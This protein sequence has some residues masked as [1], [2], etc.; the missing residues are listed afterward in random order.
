MAKMSSL[1]CPFCCLLDFYLHLRFPMNAAILPS[2]FV[3][4]AIAIHAES[5]L[6]SLIVSTVTSLRAWMPF[7]IS[8]VFLRQTRSQFLPEAFLPKVLALVS[9]CLLATRPIRTF[10]SL[11]GADRNPWHWWDQ[12]VTQEIAQWSF[13]SLTLF[14]W[15][16]YKIW[17]PSALSMIA[18]TNSKFIQ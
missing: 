6:C 13:R 14:L 12:D 5:D 4:L 1:A 7:N 8:L 15:K 10:R 3:W 11:G 9:G 2:T 16:C 18:P 17:E